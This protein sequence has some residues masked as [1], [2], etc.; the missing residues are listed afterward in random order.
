METIHQYSSY[1]FIVRYI[2]MT[3]GMFGI[4]ALCRDKQ[5][6]DLALFTFV[7]ASAVQSILIITGTAPLLS[8]ITASGFTDA[9]MT[10]SLPSPASAAAAAPMAKLRKAA[11]DFE[12]MA[13]GQL[14]KP[15]FDT[16]DNSRGPMG[17][18]AGEAAWTPMLVDQIAKHMA[19]RGGLGL[20]GPILQQMILM[21]EVKQEGSS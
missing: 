18:G 13:I 16:V 12:A 6:F 3:L 9:M 10:I 4:A 14:L 21:Q 1:D 15:M 20:A 19:A 7:L 5:A 2:N 8:S 11:E 17:G